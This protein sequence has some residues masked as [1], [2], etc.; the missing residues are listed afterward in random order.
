MQIEAENNYIACKCNSQEPYKQFVAQDQPYGNAQPTFI[1]LFAL[2]ISPVNLQII[3]MV[4]YQSRLHTLHV[5]YTSHS[6]TSFVKCS[7][8]L[9]ST[10][11]HLWSGIIGEPL[12]D[13]LFIWWTTYP[14]VSE[15]RDKFAVLGSYITYNTHSMKCTLAIVIMIHIINCQ[16]S[17]FERYFTDWIV[18]PG[19][20][21]WLQ[22][23]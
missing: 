13:C 11:S 23:A 16:H 4:S 7:G 9:R 8:S 17:E 10:K 12:F 22:N 14:S 6:V 2:L 18:N 3:S 5:I 1:S 15:T 20:Q 19:T 21:H